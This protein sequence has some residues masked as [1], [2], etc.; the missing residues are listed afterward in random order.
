M[1]AQL[2]KQTGESVRFI[3]KVLQLPRSSYHH[4]AKTT[5]S[6]LKDQHDAK[7]VKDIFQQNRR[8]YGHRRIVEELADHHV[9][10]GP[11]R[12]RRL[13]REQGLRALQ[14]RSFTPRTSDGGASAPAPNLLKD[15][16]LPNRIN[17]VWIS[18]ITYIATT[19]GWLYL[20]VIIDLYSRRLIGWHLDTHLRAELVTT[21][22]Q[23][24]LQTRG[25]RQPGL[26]LHSDRGTQYDSG[27]LRAVLGRAGIIQSMSA[28]G[29][30]YHNAW[31]E[32]FMATLK[33]ELL[34]DGA[35]FESERDARTAL[36]D[37]FQTYYNPR[38]KHS[39]L[40]YLSPK[41]FEERHA[42]A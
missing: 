27:T 17:A 23:E 5:P 32:S 24:A 14:P 6:Q 16:P 36:F 40:N 7:L 18:D 15:K 26:I 29:N 35:A 19:H 28:P 42:A 1:I 22:L 2:Q 39:A 20:A 30:P 10:C 4:G 11:R 21:A 12:V 37:Y 8:R 33:R 3:C 34:H 38:R 41:Q 13:M 31:T 25:R 9:H